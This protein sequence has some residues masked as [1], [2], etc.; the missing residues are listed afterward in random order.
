MIVIMNR[1]YIEV[2]HNPRF[3]KSVHLLLCISLKLRKKIKE[4]VKDLSRKAAESK[5]IK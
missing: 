1:I 5:K 4:K 3:L 2:K